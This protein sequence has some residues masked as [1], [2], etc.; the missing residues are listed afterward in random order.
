[1]NPDCRGRP[2]A[3]WPAAWRKSRYSSPSG[4]CVQI[5]EL[6]DGVVAVRNSRDPDG[7]ALSFTRAEWQAFLRGAREGEFS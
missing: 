6:P 5:A 3:Q 7:P 1:M 4:N 2:A